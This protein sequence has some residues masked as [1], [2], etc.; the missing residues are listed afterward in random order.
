[1]CEIVKEAIFCQYCKSCS[2]YT[3][4][5]NITESARRRHLIHDER[6]LQEVPDGVGG[7]GTLG[8]PRL[9]GGSV[10][11]GL[12]RGRVVPAEVLQGK[13]V[14]ALAGVDRDD[15]VERGPLATEAGET[16]LCVE[17]G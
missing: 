16:D 11:V 8:Q 10:E 17:W 13:T 12:L 5:V 3:P 15:A 14:A 1:M 4:T 9:D 6:L 2:S 7:L